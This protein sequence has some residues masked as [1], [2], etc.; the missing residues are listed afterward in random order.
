M[1]TQNIPERRNP[2]EQRNPMNNVYLPFMP[3]LPSKLY[4]RYSMCCLCSLLH[5]LSMYS[6]YLFL[7]PKLAPSSIPTP[8]VWV[9]HPPPL[10]L[11]DS[12]RPLSESRHPPRD[13]DLCVVTETIWSRRS[14]ATPF[15]PIGPPSRPPMTLAASWSMNFL[16]SVPRRPKLSTA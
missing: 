4:L 10:L 7:N 8:S 1:I 9:S 11:V 13:G 6:L 5:H 15:L 14:F 16:P 12:C 2:R 3:I